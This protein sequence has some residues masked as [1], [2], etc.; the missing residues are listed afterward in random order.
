[1]DLWLRRAG[2]TPFRRSPEEVFRMRFFH[3]FGWAFGPGRVDENVGRIGA[4]GV[5]VWSTGRRAFGFTPPW[6]RHGRT[7][8][9]VALRRLQGRLPGA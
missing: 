3:F 2:A 4:A 7:S 1:M 9:P 6:F 8:T 5:G